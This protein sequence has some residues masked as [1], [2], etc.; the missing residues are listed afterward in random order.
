MGL[1]VQSVKTI[2]GV[3]REEGLLGDWLGDAREFFRKQW[4][5]GVFGHF[6]EAADNRTV[7]AQKNLQRSLEHFFIHEQ[8]NEELTGTGV[9]VYFFGGVLKDR[10]FI[11]PRIKFSLDESTA[12]L[13]KG[14]EYIYHV[15]TSVEMLNVNLGSLKRSIDNT[16]A[17]I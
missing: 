1:G 5:R 16:L 14:I 6:F 15:L 13:A 9:L 12:K 17:R 4:T 11:L 8:L 7:E 2:L 3:I 10:A